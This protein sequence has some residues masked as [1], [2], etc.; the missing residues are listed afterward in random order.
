[1]IRVEY[2]DHAGDDLAVVNAARVS[3]GE[4]HDEFDDIADAGLIRFLAR[5]MPKKEFDKL[6][7]DIKH[8]ARREYV[9]DHLRQFRNTP[10]HK[11]PFNHVWA[12]FRVHMPI[13][14]ARQLVKHE[15]L[16]WN[17]RSG[18]YET[19]EWEP[20][21]Y[22]PED[23]DWR[24]EA[25]NVK[26]GSGAPLSK[27]KVAALK[28]RYGRLLREAE[29]WYAYARR[30][31]LCA[32]QARMGL[33][34]SLM[35]TVVWSGTLHAFANMCKLRLDPHAQKESR[36]VAEQIHFHLNE[37]FPVSTEALMTNGI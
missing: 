31:G 36:A 10:V 7:A 19:V 12:K 13:F 30:V 25:E 4:C 24:S 23:N 29:D 15:Y 28:M 33:P 9:V 32:E 16:P 8:D 22:W 26:Q 35:T 2:L 5:G 27:L 17:E 21:F 3:H 18:R 34:Q 20:T 6:Y 37:S 1:M 14:T 11:S